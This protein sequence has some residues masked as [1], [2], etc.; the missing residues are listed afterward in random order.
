VKNYTLYQGPVKV[1]ETLAAGRPFV[2]SPI[3]ELE[4]LAEQGLIKLVPTDDVEGWVKAVDEAVK[5][6]PNKDGQIWAKEQTWD[7]R[8]Q[9]IKDAI[10]LK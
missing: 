6:Y 8:W 4:S 10:G 7:R 3:P 5:E 9:Q 1:F 2:S